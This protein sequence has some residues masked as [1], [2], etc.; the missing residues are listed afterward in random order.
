MTGWLLPVCAALHITIARTHQA[1][2]VSNARF[3][4]V[5]NLGQIVAV[6]ARFWRG[7][8]RPGA[9][10]QWPRFMDG[11]VGET[12]LDWR[13]PHL[14]ASVIVHANEVQH[15][16]RCALVR[17]VERTHAGPCSHCDRHTR[18]VLVSRRNGTD[19]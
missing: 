4:R 16:I 18:F 8:R 12:A 5:R 2:G 19:D 6:C 13:S 14:P 3:L 10:M 7:A 11:P 17:L 1:V 15:V 9:R